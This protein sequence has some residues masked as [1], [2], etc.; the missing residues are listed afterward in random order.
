[1][2]KKLQKC[3]TIQTVLGAAE[4]TAS[5]QHRLEAG[6]VW[7]TGTVC[8]DDVLL[9]ACTVEEQHSVICVLAIEDNTPVLVLQHSNVRAHICNRCTNGVGSGKDKIL[10]ISEVFVYRHMCES[11][12]DTDGPLLLQW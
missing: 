1:M 10:V 11:G 6:T 3:E 7:R 5:H 2:Y 9:E 4:G 12:P 8:S